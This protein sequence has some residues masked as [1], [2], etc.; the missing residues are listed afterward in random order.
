M[1][2]SHILFCYHKSNITFLL[3]S[4]TPTAR[5]KLKGITVQIHEKSNDFQ[6]LILLKKTKTKLVLNADTSPEFDGW[7]KTIKGICNQKEEE[8]EIADICEDKNVEDDRKERGRQVTKNWGKTPV[9]TP[10]NSTPSRDKSKMIAEPIENLVKS[11]IESTT[12]VKEDVL[13]N[14]EHQ[15]SFC[16]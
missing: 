12:I 4:K 9:P 14:T 2:E 6:Y 3:R 5:L 10:R 7:Y 8:E 13:K 15:V 11:S 1:H 16:Y